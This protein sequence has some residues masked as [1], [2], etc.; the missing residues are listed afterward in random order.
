MVK[1]TYRK[2][3]LRVHEDFFKNL[4]E[5]ERK[6]VSDK[7]GIKLTQPAFT[8]YLSKA[9]ATITYPKKMPIQNITNNR[10]APKKIKFRYGKSPFSLI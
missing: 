5:P 1:Y 8:E 6:R 9:G 3:S 2:V 7:L 10:F 4:F